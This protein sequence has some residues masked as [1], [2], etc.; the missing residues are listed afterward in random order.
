[1]ELSELAKNI[2]III[3]A[4]TLISGIRAWKREYIGKR[5]IELAEDT[6]ML[7]YQARD[8]IRDIRNP[9][10]RIGEGSSRQKASSETASETEL[11][12][13]AYVAYERYQKHEDVFNK[14]QSTRYRFMAR[15]GRDKESPFIELNKI[16]HDIFMSAHMLGTYYWQRQGRAKMEGKEFE[17]HLNEMHEQESVFW[18]QGEDRDKIGPMVENVIKQIEDITKST[19][20]E[21]EIWFKELFRKG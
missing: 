21:K 20:A 14:L 2:S 1:M 7:F 18:Y 10:G 8:A 12:N 13:R 15:F 16:V 9:F 11:L 5:K 4:L 3:G 17:K 19:L 6:L